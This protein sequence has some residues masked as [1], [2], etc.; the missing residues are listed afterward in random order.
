MTQDSEEWGPWIEHDGKGCP[1]RGGY[2]HVKYS[3]AD[4]AGTT[5]LYGIVP[6]GAGTT[7]NSQWIW[8][9]A[10][11]FGRPFIIRYRIRKPRALRD[12]ITLVETLPAPQHH[13]QGAD[14]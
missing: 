13:T 5:E 10:I 1:V 14:V 12:L 7:I 8:D 11:R 9:R 2:V 3:A 4:L 6:Q